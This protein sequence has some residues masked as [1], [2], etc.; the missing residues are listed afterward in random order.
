MP[1]TGVKNQRGTGDRAISGASGATAHRA[2]DTTPVQGDYARMTND[3]PDHG[4]TTNPPLDRRDWVAVAD[5]TADLDAVDPAALDAAGDLLGRLLDRRW[6]GEPAGMP[7]RPTSGFCRVCGTEDK[8]TYEHV[9]PQATGNDRSAKAYDAWLALLAGA[10]PQHPPGRYQSHQRGVGGHVLC[11]LCNNH[12]GRELV[13]TYAR[14]ADDLAARMSRLPSRRPDD[15]VVVPH[16]VG[17]ILEGHPLGRVARQ[18][19]AMLMA[20]SG[21]TALVQLHPELTELVWCGSTQPPD[22]L[23]LGLALTGGKQVRLAPPH[24]LGG[25]HGLTVFQEVAATPFRWTLSWRGRHLV[26]PP[27]TTDVTAWLALPLDA[28]PRTGLDLH[29]GMTIGAAPGDTRDLAAIRRGQRI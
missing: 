10:D 27:G 9:P 3:G 4:Q 19:I 18:A 7:T 2:R 16:T 1:S 21:G 14:F 11:E 8:L 24:L 23:R 29:V 6:A 28:A 20:S 22:V 13:P 25:P 12:C 17:M 5:P 26:D 15:R